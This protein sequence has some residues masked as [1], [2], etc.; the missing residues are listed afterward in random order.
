MKSIALTVA[1]LVLCAAASTAMAQD[2]APSRS[3]R[4]VDDKGVVHYGDSVPAEFSRKQ[5]S[6]LNR[7]G[8]EVKQSAAQL[9]ANDARSADER[10]AAVAR[11]KQHD[12]F[13]LATYTSPR[14][15]EQLRDE[16]VGLVEAQIVAARGFLSSAQTRMKS[17]EQRVKT[18]KPYSDAPTARRMPDQLAEEIVRT[19]NEERL[20][21]SMVDKKGVEKE[22]LRATF[23]ADIDRYHT[24]LASRTSNS[25]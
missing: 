3:Y 11:Q 5:T 21:R 7:Q 9:S 2:K 23:Q 8:V 1:G 12:N 6:E 13:L 22:Q 10:A 17:L 15:I 14:D 24:L 4:W 25:R 19:L 18:F 16:R 20:Q